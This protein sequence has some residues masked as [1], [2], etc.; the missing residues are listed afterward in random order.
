M[1]TDQSGARG[2]TPVHISPLPWVL[3]AHFPFSLKAVASV[4]L[5]ELKDPSRVELHSQV[6]A[7]L[8]YLGYGRTVLPHN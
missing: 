7:K 8:Q 2:G 1:R 6:G 5:A 4:S 3:G